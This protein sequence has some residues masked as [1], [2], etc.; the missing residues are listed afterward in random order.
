MASLIKSL[1]GKVVVLF[2]GLALV[3]IALV[4]AI[5]SY[6]ASSALRE[7]YIDS[8]TALGEAKEQS[9]VIYLKEKIG[10][11]SDYSAF[12]RL[13]DYLKEL[14]SGKV[15][16]AQ[17]LNRLLAGVIAKLDP[18]SYETFVLNQK[19]VIV[20]ATQKDHLGLNRSS[21]EYYV[22]G[23]KDIY[24]KDIYKSD[25]TGKI[26]FA[27]SSP[28]K[29]GSSGRF[30]G[31]IVNRY[32][33][34][35]I[36]RIMGQTEGLGRSGELYL[37]NKEGFI[38][39]RLRNADLRPLEKKIDTEPFRAFLKDGKGFSGTYKDFRGEKVVGISMSDTLD[40][41]L[42]KEWLI[43]AEVDEVEAF[44]PATR[45]V[46]LIFLVFIAI[47]AAVIVIGL[48]FAATMVDPLSRLSLAAREVAKG[49]LTV[50]VGQTKNE[51]EIGELSKSFGMVLESLGTILAKTKDAVNQITSASSEILAASTQQAAGAREQSSAISETTS[52]AMEL[53][54]SSEQIGESIKRVSLATNHAVAG[55][56]KIKDAIGKTGE[57]MTS[58]SEKSQQIGKLTELINDVA[59][60][61]N[62]LAVNAAIEAARAG[63]QG[64]GFTVV[65]DEIRKLADSTAKSTKDIT[66]LIEVIQNEMSNAIMSMENSVSNVNEEV[67]LA[68]ESADSAKEIAMSATQQISGSKQIAD[69]MGSINDAMKEIAS[70][71]QQ[72]SAAA[73]QLNGLAG[74]L[75]G[76]IAKFKI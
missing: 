39:T 45:I 57:R 5:S 21:D 34:T 15:S 53:S 55:M 74:E 56:A 47:A 43:I 54:K 23:K 12:K 29:D 59:D 73:K 20:G 30:L 60:Q 31:V 52:A 48:R 8:L 9:L 46:F 37:V 62:L 58:L 70:G 61:T 49:D 65:A 3:S 18:E 44:A 25:I 19:G 40:K 16:A 67:K 64:R 13:Q 76:I 51:D 68:Q 28:I 50:K 17:D 72:A 4:G 71:A 22:H 27:V 32:D 14:E 63:E 69:A 66:A 24:L 10:R 36:N 6:V 7:E 75:N 11:A 38:L 2:L 42:K 1:K 35:T 33:L 41:E 26:G